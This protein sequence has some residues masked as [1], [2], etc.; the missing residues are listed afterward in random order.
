MG[1]CGGETAGYFHG[2]GGGGGGDGRIGG[3]RYQWGGLFL[4]G[5]V[6]RENCTLRDLWGT[7]F[8]LWKLIT[9]EAISCKDDLVSISAAFTMWLVVCARSSPW[10]KMKKMRKYWMVFIFVSCCD[11]LSNY[12]ISWTFYIM[13]EI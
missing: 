2:G 12:E 6:G 11:E 3:G 13:I 7:T 4:F 10:I 1:G 8:N 9:C 5:G